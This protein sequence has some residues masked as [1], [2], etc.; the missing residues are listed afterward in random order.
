MVFDRFEVAL[1]AVVV[2]DE[3]EQAY[4]HHQRLKAI[5]DLPSIADLLE[6]PYRMPVPIGLL[7]AA[8]IEELNT[9]PTGV[10][11]MG[12]QFVERLVRRPLTV[13]GVIAEPAQWT[14]QAEALGRFVTSAPRAAI[15]P[16]HGQP[17]TRVAAE[18]AMWGIGLI[19]PAT[20]GLAILAD[21]AR[22]TVEVRPYEWWLAEAVYDAWLASRDVRATPTPRSAA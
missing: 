17:S 20:D 16:R 2:L 21:P 4:R 15:R 1:T 7:P 19:S 8:L 13:V 6:L 18:A 9:L 14:R 12:S 5:C 3:A 11:E 10:V 22:P